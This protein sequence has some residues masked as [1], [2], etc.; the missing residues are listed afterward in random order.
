MQSFD[1]TAGI[2][3]KVE[4]GERQNAAHGLKFTLGKAYIF[5]ISKLCI[6]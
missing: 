5:D 6:Y 3:V 4:D 1:P 2:V